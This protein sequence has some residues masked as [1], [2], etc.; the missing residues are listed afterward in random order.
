M[1]CGFCM[2]VVVCLC[3]VLF[4]AADCFLVFCCSGVLVFSAD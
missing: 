3:F 4:A 2:Y 1:F